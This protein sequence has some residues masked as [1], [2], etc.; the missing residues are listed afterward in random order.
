MKLGTSS[1]S[2][3]Q[4]PYQWISVRLAMVLSV[5]LVLAWAADVYAR[6]S[7][8]RYGGRAGL[9]QSRS[10]SSGGGWSSSRPVPS[11]PYSAPPPASYGPSAP[12]MP[13]PGFG[14]LPFL[15]PFLGWGGGGGTSAGSA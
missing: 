11:R 7:G 6:S 5:F 4:T 14:F 2:D 3:R 12:M 13:S 8:G 1:Y 10:G 15:L 9:S